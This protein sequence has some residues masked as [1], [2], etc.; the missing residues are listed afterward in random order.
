MY[1]VRESFFW[2]VRFG[3]E[4]GHR[5]FDCGSVR[6]YYVDAYKELGLMC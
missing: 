6:L 5:F 1:H 3:Q 4:G 2:L